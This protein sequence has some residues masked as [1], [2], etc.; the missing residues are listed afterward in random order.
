MVDHSGRR[1]PFGDAGLAAGAASTSC[2]Q[3]RQGLGS[4]WVV[5]TAERVCES[6][7]SPSGFLG[8]SQGA[9]R[10]PMRVRVTLG[11]CVF[12]TGSFAP[13]VSCAGMWRACN[14]GNVWCEC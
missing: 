5:A 12:E 7:A 9:R 3:P 11:A 4:G 14:P 8:R 13:A 10:P 2:G 1:A 6:G